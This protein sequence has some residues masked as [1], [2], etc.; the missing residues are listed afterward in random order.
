MG[1]KVRYPCRNCVYF[2]A[3][4]D[5]NRTEFCE[6]RKTKFEKKVESN[7]EKSTGNTNF[8]GRKE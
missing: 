5:T 6:G 7:V 1:K 2:D 8:F 4:G 3:C